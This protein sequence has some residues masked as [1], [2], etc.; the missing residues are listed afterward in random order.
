MSKSLS[1]MTKS[2][3]QKMKSN[4]PANQI[5]QAAKVSDLSYWEYIESTQPHLVH[6]F[7]WGV[8]GETRK[9]KRESM[10]ALMASMGRSNNPMMRLMS[11]MRTLIGR[12][13]Y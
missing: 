9:E 5:S 8:K 6:K 7:A 3:E 2:E 12:S 1:S 4:N 11:Q 10:N 13:A